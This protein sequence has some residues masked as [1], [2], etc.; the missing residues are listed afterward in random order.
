[1][2]W[3]CLNIVN[4]NVEMS[5]YFMLKFQNYYIFCWNVQNI[6]FS[7]KRLIL[8]Y[9]FSYWKPQRRELSIHNSIHFS[10]VSSSLIEDLQIYRCNSSYSLFSIF[11]F[12]FVI[13]NRNDRTWYLCNRD[14]IYTRMDVTCS[15]SKTYQRVFSW[16]RISNRF[17]PSS[18]KTLVLVNHP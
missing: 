12:Q 15:R 8:I 5:L 10:L 7:T 3:N 6:L 13:R 9:L 2:K 14:W 4:L 17:S 11:L 1:M 16:E 18:D